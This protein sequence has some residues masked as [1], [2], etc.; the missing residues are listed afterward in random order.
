MA[1]VQLTAYET[2]GGIHWVLMGMREN[3]TG[4]EWRHMATGLERVA[5]DAG[6]LGDIAWVAM[7]RAQEL[8]VARP[9]SSL[10]GC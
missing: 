4:R 6:D 10:P 8:L 5:G 2:V 7:Q 9:S 1:M 3:A